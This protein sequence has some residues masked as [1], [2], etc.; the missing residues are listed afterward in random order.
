VSPLLI[1]ARP[2]WLTNMASVQ[3]HAS[4]GLFPF[5]MK[6][7][8]GEATKASLAQVHYHATRHDL[9]ENTHVLID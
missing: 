1:F 6:P 5:A 2:H 3:G 4:I 9:R 7:P 8:F